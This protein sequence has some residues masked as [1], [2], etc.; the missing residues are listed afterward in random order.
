MD[1]FSQQH[2][3]LLFEELA[4]AVTGW[5]L[6]FIQLSPSEGNC[7]LQQ[8]ASPNMLFSRAQLSAKFEQRGGPSQDYRTFAL[9]APGCPALKWCRQA[10]TQRSLIVFPANGD[11]NSISQPGFHMY[12]ASLSQGLLER[13]SGKYFQCELEDILG[14]ERNV[15]HCHP[16]QSA[17]LRGLF[18]QL[19]RLSSQNSSHIPSI[20]QQLETEIGLQLLSSIDSNPSQWRESK[21]NK[22]QRALQRSLELID[23]THK[24]LNV[25]DLLTASDASLRTL[26]YA[27]LDH[28]SI[29]PKQYLKALRLRQFHHQLLTSHVDHSSSVAAIA[30]AQNFRPSGQ[31][32]KEYFDFFG[33][34]PS[35]TLRRKS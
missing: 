27:F 23:A 7:L 11:F 20:F 8:M 31:L 21:K 29:S 19:S 12:T 24:E 22:R 14:K 30:E 4:C 17:K 3:F 15:V 28:F 25:G 1:F 10:I 35:Q 6:D 33:E 16:S 5:N 34:L 2:K 26:E 13:I 9:M 32:S 18:L